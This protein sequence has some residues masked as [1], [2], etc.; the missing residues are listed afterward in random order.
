[1]KKATKKPVEIEYFTFEEIKALAF[2]SDK[3]IDCKELDFRGHTIM[4]YDKLGIYN[5][6][7][8]VET[9]TGKVNLNK[10]YVIIIG[11]QNEIYPCKID[12]FNE[13]YDIL[14]DN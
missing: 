11:V 2:A 14:G 7:L 12:I 6:V 10:N 1:M 9:L 8:S 5:D 4:W 3:T 13:T